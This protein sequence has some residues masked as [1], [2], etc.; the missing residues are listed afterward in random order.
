MSDDIDIVKV[1]AMVAAVT[2]FRLSAAEMPR[3]G[4]RLGHALATVSA[5]LEASHQAPQA[6][7]LAH[8]QPLTDGFE[9]SAGFRVPPGSTVPTTLTR[10]ELGS[11]EAVHTTHIGSYATL[12]VAYQDVMGQASRLGESM[13]EEYWSGPGTSE[14]EARTEIYWPLASTD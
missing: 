12:S 2:R 9:V 1:P 10:L 5:E 14:N 7:A 8:Y 6:P 11:V 3:I 4:E 13:W